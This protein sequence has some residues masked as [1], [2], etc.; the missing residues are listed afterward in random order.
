[1]KRRI[2]F[3]SV[4]RA[5]AVLL[6]LLVFVAAAAWYVSDD[7]RYVARAGYEEGRI[8]LRRK[9]IARL[10]AD[11][12]TDAVTRAKLQLVL[13]ARAFAADSLGLT[14]G[15]TFTT[16]S[17]VDRD[18]L[19]VVLSAS[20]YDRLSEY[21]W[22]YPV[23]GQVPYKGFFSL[24]KATEEARRLEHIGMDTYIR[25]SG[26]FS[27][28]G[29]FNDPLLSTVLRDDS[30]ELAATV[31]HE[32]LHNTV[33]VP[34]SVPFNE[35]F[36]NFV[37]YRGAEAFF[38]SRGE[39]RG[40][41]RAAARWRDEVRLGRFYADL[42]TR[43]DALYAPGIAGP[44]L[45]EERQR[46]FREAQAQLAGAVGRSLETVSGAALAERPLNNASVLAER[47]YLTGL[48]GFDRVL[49][50]QKGVVRA[51]VAEVAA[52]VAGGG[53]PWTAVAGGRG[54]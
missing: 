53:D 17:R 45:R 18:T 2:T 21:L 25:P 36:A 22:S 6:G 49:A 20:R 13:A 8:L 29:W 50:A 14:A 7:V 41:D 43:L 47:F 15:K 35:S 23:V 52:K 9:S 54:R 5:L 16:F 24:A 40:A 19:V 38:R 11:S 34:G 32:I 44:S 4:R 3:R 51:A 33:W 1:M 37:G 26:A 10:V 31:I 39:R 12:A 48:E 46:I 30:V 28:L 42:A 27:T